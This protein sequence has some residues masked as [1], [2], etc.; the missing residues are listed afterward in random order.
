M[1]F[2]TSTY[3]LQFFYLQLFFYFRIY[4][5]FVYSCA[6]Y[7]LGYLWILLVRR[8]NCCLWASCSWCTNRFNCWLSFVFSPVQNPFDE[9]Y[10]YCTIANRVFL[11]NMCLFDMPITDLFKNA[12]VIAA[13]ILSLY[14]LQPFIL[15][16]SITLYPDSLYS[17][18]LVFLTVSIYRYYI[19]KDI[20]SFVLILSGLLLSI[21][22]RSNGV[23]L[24]YIPFII[25]AWS[26]KQKKNL[27][28]LILSYSMGFILL[29]IL[30][31]HL[32][33]LCI[34]IIII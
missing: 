30:L 28:K 3:G 31:Q 23:F 15:R 13:F 27:K 11:F 25:I 33:N 4:L 22:F 14:V 16:N 12:S 29:M 7:R 26:Y 9:Y 1:L 20:F 10:S 6:V 21:L 17:S 2:K 18:A 32:K 8:K 19:K 5:F 24:Y 34:R